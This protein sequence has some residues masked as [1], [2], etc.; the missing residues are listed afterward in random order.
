MPSRH[1]HRRDRGDDG[2]P[3]PARRA[4]VRRVSPAPPPAIGPTSWP[5][6]ATR[7]T[8]N[9]NQTRWAGDLFATVRYGV[10]AW[11][12]ARLERSRFRRDDR[13]ARAGRCRL[14]PA[15]SVGRRRP[16][17]VLARSKAVARA[18]REDEQ[19]D[20]RGG[21]RARPVELPRRRTCP[22]R[23]ASPSFP[24]SHRCRGSSSSSE[25]SLSRMAKSLRGG[26][27]DVVGAAVVDAS[28]HAHAGEY[29]TTQSKWPADEQHV[30]V[31]VEIAA[32]TPPSVPTQKVGSAAPVA[33]AKRLTLRW[34]SKERPPRSSTSRRTGTRRRRPPDLVHLRQRIVD[35]GRRVGRE[36]RVTCPVAAVDRRGARGTSPVHLA[37]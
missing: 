32:C 12:A 22:P 27:E 33:A 37:N 4:A 28:R 18:H 10:S 34:S 3:T 16:A 31:Q 25:P 35:S 9:T 8:A 23:R 29:F 30:E 24:G 13:C 1:Q 20:A 36:R 26:S 11:S 14:A 7:G 6:C 15:R 2:L 19:I 17:P 21:A 5:T